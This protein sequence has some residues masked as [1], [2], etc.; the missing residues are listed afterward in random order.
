MTWDVIENNDGHYQHSYRYYP[1]EYYEKLEKEYPRERVQATLKHFES[2][3]FY[4]MLESL[5][6]FQTDIT[7]ESYQRFKKRNPRMDKW[8][9]FYKRVFIKDTEYGIQEFKI[10]PDDFDDYN[11]DKSR[12]ILRNIG[13]GLTRGSFNRFL[14]NA[15]RM[16]VA[17]D[18]DEWKK[19][20][21]Y[22]PRMKKWI[23]LYAWSEHL[24]RVKDF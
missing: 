13:N 3:R 15:H 18:P 4:D 19:F 11:R 10:E 24:R 16:V 17:L 6:E 21:K 5:H 20:F 23:D 22:N 1:L 12:H 8:L 7:K 2:G 9:R 14:D